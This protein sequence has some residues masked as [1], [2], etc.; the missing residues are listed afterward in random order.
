MRELSWEHGV[1]RPAFDPN[2]M[3]AAHRTLP[4]GTRIRVTNLANEMRTLHESMVSR[5]PGVWGRVGLLVP[6]FLG[7][8]LT[9]G[10]LALLAQNVQARH[11]RE[12]RLLVES[13]PIHIDT[14]Q[15]WR[16]E[17]NERDRAGEPEAAARLRAEADPL[18]AALI[19]DW[20]SKPL[21]VR[22]EAVI[23]VQRAEIA[24]TKKTRINEVLQRVKEIDLPKRGEE[25]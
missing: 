18:W 21:K 3:T 14:I 10:T 20:K 7:I 24:A 8:A 15:H 2:E 5:Q 19:A 17:A 1:S 6:Y 16:R 25:P 23:Q 22:L 4:F 11:E 9:V 12:T 13:F